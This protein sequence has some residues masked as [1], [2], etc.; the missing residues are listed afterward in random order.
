MKRALEGYWA[1]TRTPSELEAVASGLRREHWRGM[2]ASGIDEL[3]SNDFSLYDHV[4][5]A[6]VL[7]GAVPERYRAVAD[8][9]ARY[10]AMARGLQG[11]GFDL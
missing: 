9:L 4:L 10:F 5:D 2:R 1:G 6:A 11:K 8:P 7:V 3:P